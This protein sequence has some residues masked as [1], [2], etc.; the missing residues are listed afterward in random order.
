[1]DH[2]THSRGDVQG[3]NILITIL[4][5]VLI[6]CAQFI[7]GFISGSMAL[8]SDAAHNFSD[9]LSLF[10]SYW[11]IRLSRREQ[12]LRQTYG[13]KRAE[14]FAAFINT[15]VLLVIASLLIYEAISRLVNPEPITGSI[16]I[17]LAAAGILLNGLSL[18]FIRKD[19]SKNM[20]IRSAYLH[21][22]MDMLT[23]VAVLAGGIVMNYLE[24][25]W[26]DGVL[27]IIIALYL[28][29]SSW[30]IF[31]QSIR[32]F[33]QFTPHTIDI[34][35]I[36][37]KITSIPGIK[38]IHHVHAWQ[39]DDHEIMLE[40]HIDLDNDYTVSY[41]EDI[42]EKV[43]KIL[44]RE[45]IHHFNIQPELYRDDRKELINISKK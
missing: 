24:W 14:I 39:L 6:T 37:H 3:K 25:F 15:A 7:G 32:I 43:E 41:F 26:I 30:G 38:N 33:M 9:V 10:I 12:T 19:A 5:N 1:M 36:A 31:Y 16:V 22:F 40:A 13:Y 23:S 35:E 2:S 18:L 27:S 44:D 34:E 8:L 45:G 28:L 20:N 21:L 29:Y 42:L 17:Y 4:L 11:A